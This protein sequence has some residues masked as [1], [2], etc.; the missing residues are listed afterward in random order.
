MSLRPVLVLLLASALL[1]PVNVSAQT[2]DD[3]LVS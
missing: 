1:T 2:K 3:T